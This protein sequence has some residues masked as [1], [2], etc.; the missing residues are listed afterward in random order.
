[1]SSLTSVGIGHRQ[2]AQI[3]MQAKHYTHKINL[4][5]NE[6]NNNN[7]QPVGAA[8]L[9]QLRRQGWHTTASPKQILLHCW[10]DCHV[11][12]PQ[13]LVL[14]GPAWKGWWWPQ[15]PEPAPAPGSTE[16]PVGPPLPGVSLPTPSHWFLLG[17]A[18]SWCLGSAVLVAVTVP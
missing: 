3:H 14:P 15:Q 13:S 5:T 1:M 17:F 9:T 4:K 12:D 11:G 6:N 2:G 16:R 8:M 18:P 10:S 7:P